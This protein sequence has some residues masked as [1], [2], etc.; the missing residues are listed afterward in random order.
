MGKLVNNYENPLIYGKNPLQKIVSI[1]AK[2]DSLEIFTQ[3][4]NGDI[5]SSFHDNVYWLLTPRAINA[6]FIELHGD[7]H[8]KYA[9]TFRDRSDFFKYKQYLK[10]K[11]EDFYAVGDAKEAIMLRNGYTYF[12]GM[13]VKDISILSFDI[14]TTGLNHDD[15]SKILLIS[16]TY[17]SSTGKI[18]RGLFCYDNYESQGEMLKAWVRFISIHN[19]SILTGHNILSFDLPYMQYIADKEN[20]ELNLGRDNSSINFDKYE[21]KFR[22]DGSQFY[23]YK[24]AKIY[25]REVIDTLFLSIKYDATERKFESYGL[26]NIIKQLGLEKKDRV[27]YDASKIRFNYKIPEEWV[28]IKQYCTDDGD[29]PITLFDLMSPAFFYWTQS[30]PKSFQSV[31]ESATGSQ[32][33]SIMV[34]AYLQEKHSI[35]K[36]NEAEHYEGAISHGVPGVYRNAFK[37]DVASLYP[38]IMIKYKVGDKNKDPKGYFQ[39]LVLYF[40]TE[41]LKNKKLAKTSKYHD[42]LQ[43]S[44]KIAINSAYGFLGTAGLNFNAPDQAAFITKKGREILGIAIQWATGKDYETWKKFNN[45]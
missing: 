14:E 40:T 5:T 20:I 13:E 27:Y 21:S 37:V 45:L 1:E 2:D 44:Q 16:N 6:G 29:D 15:E 33:N 39:E 34:R 25:G 41:R 26:K 3:N 8:Y 42:D 32:I 43:A 28:K 36:A 35:P 10:S 38:S 4:F 22:K 23:H 31:I 12:K 17:R 24:K 7:L 9:K 30:I 19:P 11:N 18:I